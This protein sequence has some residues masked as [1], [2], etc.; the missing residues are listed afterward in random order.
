[1]IDPNSRYSPIEVKTHTITGADGKERKLRH[2]ARR[3]LPAA[4]GGTTLLE[5][6]VKTGDRLDRLA[7]R[8]LGDPTQFWQLADAN[9]VLRPE[10][11]T[12]LPGRPIVVALPQS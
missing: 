4:D 3:F 8:Y 9:L 1:M 5:H 12:D 10:E 2:L 7:A 6:K 11:M